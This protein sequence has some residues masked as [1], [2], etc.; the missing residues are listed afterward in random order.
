[1]KAVACYI[2]VSSGGKPQA[3][4]RRAIN[5]WLKD[6]RISAKSVRW[7]IDKETS[8]KPTQPELER[9]RGDISAGGIGA[10]VVW[11]FDRLSI[12]I[13]KGLRVLRDLLKKPLRIVSISQ[14]IDVKG[15]AGKPVAAVVNGLAEMAYEVSQER[16]NAGVAAARAL[17][18]IGGRPP[19]TADHPKVV[20]AK[21]LCEA[22]KLSDNAI[23]KRLKISKSTYLRYLQL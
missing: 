4:Q 17:G 22:G 15:G 13:T 5:Q 20:K 21:E 8:D 19:I 7:Y 16:T 23:C 11:H 2:R 1:M 6:N 3:G 10:V 9:L 12:S 14:D 18:R